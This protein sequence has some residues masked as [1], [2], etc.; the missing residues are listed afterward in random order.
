MID[1]LG[2]GIELQRKQIVAAFS[3]QQITGDVLGLPIAH[4]LLNGAI[5]EARVPCKP[6]LGRCDL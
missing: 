2:V 5:R 1:D 3:F 4:V 6:F